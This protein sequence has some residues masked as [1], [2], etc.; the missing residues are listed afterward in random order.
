MLQP[1][2]RPA[3][4]FLTNP[5]M[6]VSSA[7]PPAPTDQLTDNGSDIEAACGTGDEPSLRPAARL[8]AGRAVSARLRP[9]P[10]G[11]YRGFA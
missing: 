6:T 8:E 2:C 11:A 1:V 9:C 4:M 3:I 5:A 7:P 10:V